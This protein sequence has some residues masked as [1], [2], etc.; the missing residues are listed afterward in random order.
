MWKSFIAPALLVAICWA[1]SR[2]VSSY[3]IRSLESV[4][5]KMILEDLSSIIAAHSMERVLGKA[6]QALIEMPRPVDRAGVAQLDRLQEEFAQHLQTGFAEAD[7]DREI[8]REFA[9]YQQ[10]IRRQVSQVPDSGDQNSISRTRTLLALGGRVSESIDHLV[11]FNERQMTQE[12]KDRSRL[13]TSVNEMRHA[14]LLVGP[15]AGI[16]CGFWVSRRFHRSIAQ[17][18]ITL[19]DAASEI[20]E[21]VGRV[22]VNPSHGLPR[23]QEQVNRIVVRIREVAQQLQEARRQAILSARLAALGQMAAGVAHELRNP[24]TSVKLLI[25]TTIQRSGHFMGEQRSRVVLEEICRMENTIERM[26]D[27][28]RPAQMNCLLIDLRAVVDRACELIDGRAQNAKVLL[29]RQ[30]PDTPV[31]IHADAQQLH[32]VFTNVLQNGIEATSAGGTM[33]IKIEGDENFARVIISDTGTG[34]SPA[35]MD[36]L[37]EP[38]ATGKARGT[39]LGLAISYRIV[40]DHGGRLTAANREGEGAEFTVELPLHVCG[41]SLDSEES[42]AQRITF[43]TMSLS[44]GQVVPQ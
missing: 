2:A 37:F 31:H 36:H 30:T 1:F 7:L 21:P 41:G 43:A 3:Y 38:F 35:V 34:I 39:G 22:E 17:I 33:N 20:R 27:F 13:G 19:G 8:Q 5:E 23:L 10:E 15:I 28:A 26:L 29:I 42:P 16:L 4:P 11:A 18:S 32:Q 6:N 25:Q 14:L 12:A 24:L 40:Q 44:P 9:R